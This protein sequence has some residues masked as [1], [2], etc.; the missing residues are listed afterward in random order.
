MSPKTQF[1]NA[2][3]FRTERITAWPPKQALC[4]LVTYPY[5][6]KRQPTTYLPPFLLHN[7][8]P[9]SWKSNLSICQV[10]I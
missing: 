4:W 3:P 8:I 7:H 2:P 1:N 10:R 6:L 9:S 5:G